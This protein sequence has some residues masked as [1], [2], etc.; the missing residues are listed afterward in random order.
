MF[1]YSGN[2]R[3]SEDVLLKLKTIRDRI[4]D[5]QNV[6]DMVKE[7]TDNP[8]FS[9]AHGISLLEAKVSSALTG[10]YASF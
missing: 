3:M 8:D 2:I 5:V 6:L 7:H 10:L 9:T 1:A 4:K